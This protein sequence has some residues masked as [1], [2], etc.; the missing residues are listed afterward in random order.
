MWWGDSSTCVS[1]FLLAISRWWADIPW[2]LATLVLPT[3]HIRQL[4]QNPQVYE[5]G[6]HLTPMKT[7]CASTGHSQ[8]WLHLRED[9]EQKI[10]GGVLVK[11]QW[12]VTHRTWSQ[13]TWGQVPFKA[14]VKYLL[15]CLKKKPNN[16]DDVITE[17]DV[18][19]KFSQKSCI[20]EL[21]S[22]V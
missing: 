9:K 14:A 4:G 16:P 17:G 3:H 13:E 1:N 21:G 2:V 20:K 10:L 22:S 19:K 5:A 18:I 6:F 8:Q 12:W 7:H 11:L 15:W